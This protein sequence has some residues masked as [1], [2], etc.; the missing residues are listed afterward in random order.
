MDKNKLIDADNRLEVTKGVE[1]GGRVKWVKGLNC[2]I[3]QMDGNQTF[4]DETLQYVKI[5]NYDVDCFSLD[6]L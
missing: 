3:V 1:G 5:L 4:G 2:I 6:F